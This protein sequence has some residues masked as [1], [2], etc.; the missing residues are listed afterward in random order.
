M[1]PFSDSP[2][3]WPRL[4]SQT[5]SLLLPPGMAEEVASPEPTSA[6]KGQ[7]A[8]AS[9]SLAR[10]SQRVVLRRW[11]THSLLI[12]AVI[13]VGVLAARSLWTRR[14]PRFHQLT[15]RR[16]SVFTARFAPYGRAVLYIAEWDGNPGRTYSTRPEFPESR[17]L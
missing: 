9:A 3:T 11:M 7:L 17:S 6:S 5:A 13:L 4:L 14:E 1:T 16:G 15:F 8:E 12:V 10:K 2:T